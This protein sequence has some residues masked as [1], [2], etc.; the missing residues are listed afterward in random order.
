MSADTIAFLSTLRPPSARSSRRKSTCSV[1]SIPLR[2]PS[3]SDSTTLQWQPSDQ[4]TDTTLAASTHTT[5]EPSS[6]ARATTPLRL[7]SSPSSE[8]LT[9][10]VTLESTT[11]NLLSSSELL[12]H[13]AVEASAHLD[14]PQEPAH[15]PQED[16]LP[17]SDHP[18]QSARSPQLSSDT[19]HQAEEDHSSQLETKTSSSAA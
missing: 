14:L 13:P 8:E 18:L 12:S 9:P 15:H 17:H 4:L 16:H 10:M 19:H 7:S 3:N 6:L 5:S 2:V 11:A 1:A